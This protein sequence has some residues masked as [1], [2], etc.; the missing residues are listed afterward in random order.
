MLVVLF[1]PVSCNMSPE[2]SGTIIYLDEALPLAT[3]VEVDFPVKP[4]KAE[5]SGGPVKVIGA[6]NRGRAYAQYAKMFPDCM[7][8]VGVSVIRE[9]RKN[10]MDDKY[11]IPQEHRFNDWSQQY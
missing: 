7:Q 5:I 10:A 6:G 3:D 9:S 4:L 1:A 11:G 8:V 2:K